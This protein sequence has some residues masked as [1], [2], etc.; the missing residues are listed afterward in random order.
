M[1][2]S[3][4]RGLSVLAM[5]TIQGAPFVKLLFNI[6]EFNIMPPGGE[7]TAITLQRPRMGE[8]II[9]IRRRLPPSVSGYIL[10]TGQRPALRVAGVPRKG[11]H[12]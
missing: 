10:R 7:G 2:I 4:S 3:Q 5:T 12:K 11:G 9:V 1:E 8:R 6:Y